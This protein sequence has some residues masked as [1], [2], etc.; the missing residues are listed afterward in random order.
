MPAEMV[1][2]NALAASGL[3]FNRVGGPSTYPYQP[4]TIWDGLA[5]DP[6]VFP[7]VWLFGD[8]GG[9]R[10]HYFLLTEP[11]TSRPGSL[12]ENVAAGTVATLPAGASLETELAVR[13][14]L[15]GQLDMA[16]AIA[17]D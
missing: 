3:L 1:R 5:F 16:N 6:A 9:W 13:I 14:L 2:D 15:P 8:Y 7:A 11:C 4:D 12:L 10:G 17:F